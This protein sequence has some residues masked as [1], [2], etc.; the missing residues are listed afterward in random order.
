M[1]PLLTIFSL[2]S[3]AL[4]IA[5]FL[6]YRIGY[7]HGTARA[8]DDEAFFSAIALD[9][10]RSEGYKSGYDQGYEQGQTEG[11]AQGFTDGRAYNEIAHHN[12]QII[13]SHHGKVYGYKKSKV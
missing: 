5:I 13:Q 3:V 9:N 11:R 4:L 6:A 7:E 12:A 2:I 1:F 8:T 10:A